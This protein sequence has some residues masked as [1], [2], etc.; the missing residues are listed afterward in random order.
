MD[1]Q[2]KHTPE[3]PENA[4]EHQLREDFDAVKSD[5][6]NLW[7]S[8]S[9]LFQSGTDAASER[10]SEAQQTMEQKREE[11]EKRFTE[12][13]EKVEPAAG[14]AKTG[15]VSALNELKGAYRRAR[16]AYNQKSGTDENAD[17]SADQGEGTQ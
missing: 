16:E 7:E 5:M 4:D 6:S 8:A 11:V 15:I 13:R 1:P 10:W 17:A 14:E 2:Q 3:T 9:H 12:M